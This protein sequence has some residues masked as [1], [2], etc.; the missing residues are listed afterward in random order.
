MSATVDA[1][2]I[3]SYMN[4]CPILKV[5][6]RTFPVTSF[7]LEDVI[8]LTGYWLDKRS[9]S[10]YLARQIKRKVVTLKTFDADDEIPTLDDDDDVAAMDASRLAHTYAKSTR[11]VLELLDEHQIN[12]D[13]IILLLEQICLLNPS[14][15]ERFSNAILVF[16]PVSVM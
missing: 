4:G 11:E 8:E 16:L 12:M 2:K 9:D 1:E 14:L 6:G 10:P 3:S 15:V 7:F 13:L 5:P